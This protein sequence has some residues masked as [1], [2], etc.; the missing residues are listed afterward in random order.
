[1]PIHPERV[2]RRRFL[3]TG[4]AA[5]VGTG[6]GAGG[7]ALLSSHPGVLPS[8]IN[9]VGAARLRWVV[10]TCSSAGMPAPKWW[11]PGIPRTPSAI[12]ESCWARQPLA[13]A[14]SWWPRPG[15]TGMRSQYRGAR[16]PRSPDQP[17][18]RYRLRLRRGARRYNSGARDRTDRTVGSKP[19]RF[20]SFGDQST[21]ALGRLADGRYVS[22]NIGSPSPVT[23]R[24]RSSVLPRC[25]T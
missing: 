24:L 1:M 10:C 20:T 4:A 7:T 3:T 23:S 9:V 13:S 16:Q 25:S 12:R 19:L 15:R 2:S 11:C 22:D 17:D 5:V 8:G 6:V 18:T 21:P 14:A